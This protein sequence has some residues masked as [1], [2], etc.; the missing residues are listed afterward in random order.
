ME[1]STPGKRLERVSRCVGDRR[2]LL[3]VRG[4]SIVLSEWQCAYIEG[5]IWGIVVIEEETVIGE[6]EV[7]FVVLYA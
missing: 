5:G 4:Q 7:E 6:D 3:L 2:K 1:I